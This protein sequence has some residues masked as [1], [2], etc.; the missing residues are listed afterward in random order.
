M[1]HSIT[2]T[3][4]ALGLI[5]LAMDAHIA[6]EED[7]YTREDSG[8]DADGDFGNDLHHLRLL[9]AD[10]GAIHQTGQ[11]AATH[12]QCWFDPPDN[13]LSLL[14]FQDVQR[15]RDQGQLSNKAVLRYEFAAHS[16]EEAAAIRN[17]REGW[18]PYVPMGDAAPCPT[19]GAN[20]YPEGYGDCWHCGHIG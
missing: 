12:Y 20:Y 13:G 2:L 9:R 4:K 18:A 10:L 3:P 17:L 1:A 8:E 16:G 6:A 5:L 14:R 7:R 19:C 11:G 15:V